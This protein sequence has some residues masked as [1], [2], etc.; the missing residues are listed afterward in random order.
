MYKG[1]VRSKSARARGA[2][3]F[4]AVFALSLVGAVGCESIPAP[5]D[6]LAASQAAIRAAE[7]VGAEK[8]PQAALHLKLAH[9][10]F[11]KAK[12]MMDAADNEIALRLLLRSEADAEV[13][14]AFAK[15]VSSAEAA[16]E[17]EKQ[18]QK[19]KGTK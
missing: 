2:H 4:L 19:L 7:E 13:A 15:K 16:E 8:D 17:A 5:V 10:Q 18:I 1:P 12:Q 14:R 6:Q 11:D 9:E 3:T